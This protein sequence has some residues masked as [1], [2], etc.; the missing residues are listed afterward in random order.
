[1]HCSFQLAPDLA[2]HVIGDVSCVLARAADTEASAVPKAIVLTKEHKALFPAERKRIEKAGG[3]VTNG[4]LQ[5]KPSN[6][7]GRTITNLYIRHF[8]TATSVVEIVVCM[9]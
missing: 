2:C 3:M 8:A 9:L 4:R 6:C 7:I 1:M 5:G